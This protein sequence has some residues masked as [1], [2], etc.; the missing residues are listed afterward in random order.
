MPSSDTASSPYGGTLLNGLLEGWEGEVLERTRA[1]NSYD[2]DKL[3]KHFSTLSNEA[4][5]HI[6]EVRRNSRWELL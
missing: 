1:E 3:G 5:L 2:M 4:A 6:R